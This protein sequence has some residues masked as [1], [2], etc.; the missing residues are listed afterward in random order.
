LGLDTIKGLDKDTVSTG[1]Y[2]L[3]SFNVRLLVKLKNGDTCS[4]VKPK[5][6]K[7]GK[8]P[9]TPIITANK[10]NLCDINQTVKL[11]TNATGVAKYTWNIGQ[12]LYKDSLATVTHKFIRS[13]Y[14]DV[15]IKIEDD[16]GCETTVLYD[17]MI[18]V[19]RKPQV[20]LGI[21]DTAFCDTHTVFLKPKYNMY[22]QKGFIYD[23]RL[24]G[25]SISG[26]AQKNPGKLFYNKRG[27]YTFLLDA[28][29]PGNCKYSYTFPDTL[30]I[31]NSV[32]LAHSKTSTAPCN[33]QNFVIKLKNAATFNANLAWKFQGDSLQ[34]TTS[35]TEASITYHKIGSYKYTITHN[36]LGCISQTIGA[37][38][39]NLRTLKSQFS[40]QNEC[41]CSPQ[42][43][44]FV[45]NNSKS[46][47]AATT[48]LWL[49]TDSKDKVVFSSNKANPQI[50][51]NGYG[52]YGVQLN[53]KDTSG[54]KDS[55]YKYGAIRIE[56]PDLTVNAQPKVACVGSD[57]V[58][59][60]DSICELGFT[61]AQWKFYDED[62][63][64]AGTS[65]DQFPVMSFSK[66]GK[67]SVE[68]SYKTK[69]CTDNVVKKNVFEV[70]RLQSI[71]YVLSDTT[72]C[73]GSVINATLKVEPE[74]IKP[75]VEQRRGTYGRRS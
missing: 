25:S 65:T 74:N 7:V 39:V 3:G 28:Y 75:K 17:S 43:T 6:I 34:K 42:D 33:E 23:W 5:F 2:K 15:G 58:F 50:I 37:N 46:T 40:I 21:G 32:N 63:N 13:G 14:F 52:V 61:K 54:C 22:S 51:L 48:Y 12:I 55:L 29:S 44:F 57:V 26:S 60:V 30:R 53:I 66:P 41:S 68:L 27:I 18:L 49:V 16:F 10:L 69:K 47:N 9:A 70:V 35:N 8:A 73:E 36:D 24:S 38:T 20:F 59:G 64:L 56:Q 71:N 1:Y 67:Y 11:K 31:G 62:N 4:V 45:N 72:P 19:E